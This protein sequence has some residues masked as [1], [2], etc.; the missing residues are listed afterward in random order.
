MGSDA[1]LESQ[2]GEVFNFEH[3]AGSMVDIH[4][5]ILPGVDDGPRSLDDAIQMLRLAEKDGIK[6]IIATPHAHHSN[7]REIPERVEQLH[8]AAVQSGLA[9]AILSGSEVRIAPDLVER[10]QSGELITLNDTSYVLIE[11]YLHHQWRDSTVKRVICRLM[12]AGLTPI[13]AHP[14]RYPYLRE[15]PSFIDEL[16]GS[17]VFMQINAPSLSGYH[18]ADAQRFAWRLIER[19]SV[20]LIASDAHNARWRPPLLRSAYQQIASHTSQ[21]VARSM[22]DLAASICKLDAHEDLAVRNLDAS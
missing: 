14:E 12:N 13:L 20:H 1:E 5:H 3:L 17:G 18:G 8:A 16:V 21:A 6:S 7:P 2:A 11:L 22:A 10:L 4:A 15:N 9:I 19:G